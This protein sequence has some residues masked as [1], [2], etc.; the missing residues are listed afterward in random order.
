MRS[1]VFAQA[2]AVLACTV[3]ISIFSGVCGQTDEVMADTATAAAQDE[4]Q[5]LTA[6]VTALLTNIDEMPGFLS[7]GVAD[8][9]MECSVADVNVAKEDKTVVSVS[10]EE[11]TK[12]DKK[13]KSA[14]T[15]KDAADASAWGY[16]DLGIANVR[17]YL[18]VR[19]KPS[20]SSE[21]VGKMTSKDACE[22]KETKDGWAKI[23]S[24]EVSGYVK[25]EYLLTGSEAAKEA[26]DASMTYAKVITSTLRVREKASTDSTVLSLVSKG[27][28]LDVV[29]QDTDD[30]V[31]VQM[32]DEEGYVSAEFVEIGRKLPT[33]QKVTKITDATDAADAINDTSATN[34]TSVTAEEEGVS[35]AKSDLVSTALQYVGNPYRWG[36]SS[37]TKG[38]DCSG[39][40]MKIYAQYGISLPHSSRAQPAYG[41]KVSVSEAKPGDLLFYGSGR[42]I[43]HVAIYIGN[44]KIVHASNSRKG[45]TVSNAYYRTPV[46]AARYLK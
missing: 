28:E 33:A 22:I 10:S 40:T 2:A 4:V 44:G 9:I 43:N 21:V 27:E 11:K 12:K 6:G 8:A 5:T 41:T 25:A 46:C 42:S 15:K 13:D 30:W 19:E 38:T 32:D 23:T 29:D 17:E 20:T 35:S 14:G 34:D 3:A 39:F 45:I 16:T 24:G 7:A 37:L 31:K 18:N 1:R 36:G 26:E